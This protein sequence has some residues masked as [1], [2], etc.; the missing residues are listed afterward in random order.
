MVASSHSRNVRR[1]AAR[2]EGRP[3]QPQSAAGAEG[4][5]PAVPERPGPILGQSLRASAHLPKA[6]QIEE[7]KSEAARAEL[8]R[9]DR[10]KAEPPLAAPAAAGAELSKAEL[11][12]TEFI[13]AE[14]LIRT[15]LYPN[16]LPKT[17]PSKSESAATE[18]AIA[19]QPPSR[20]DSPPSPDSPPAPTPADGPGALLDVLSR[21]EA[22]IAALTD[23]KPKP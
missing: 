21:A 2:V 18:S 20:T 12:K 11:P 13:R 19:A 10:P 3:L 6:V 15:D 4:K 9:T 1:S 14:P 23:G 22:E 17:E 7:F 16:E 5:S 8:Y